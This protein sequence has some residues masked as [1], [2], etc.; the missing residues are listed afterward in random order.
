MCATYV[1]CDDVK[2]SILSSDLLSTL[3]VLIMINTSYLDAFSEVQD[4]P[5][6]TS[7]CCAKENEPSSPSFSVGWP[8]LLLLAMNYNVEAHDTFLLPA[9]IL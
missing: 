1:S 9:L 8:D 5:C 2:S 7:T 3:P 4:K 6:Y